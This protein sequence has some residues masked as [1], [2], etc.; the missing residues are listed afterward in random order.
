MHSSSIAS[1]GEK[2]RGF[3]RELPVDE[4]DLDTARRNDRVTQ[5]LRA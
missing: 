2:R 3:A 1:A 4:L 5:P